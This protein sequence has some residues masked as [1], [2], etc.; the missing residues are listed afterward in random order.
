MMLI[1]TRFFFFLLLTA[2]AYCQSFNFSLKE[3]IT[4][5]ETVMKQVRAYVE[6]H[7]G[8]QMRRIG[9]QYPYIPV[10][11]IKNRG[12]RRFSDGIYYFSTSA[13]DSGRLFIAQRGAVTVLGSG[14]MIETLTDFLSFLKKHPH[15]PEP[16]QATYLT[17]VSAYMKFW[18]KNQHEL[19]DAG[20]LDELK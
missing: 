7:D 5:P 13:H 14:S 1:I 9:K 10:F 20:A 16:T 4:P 2:P 18:F 11:T 6:L 17:V 8:T 3:A 12:E 15:L 19:I